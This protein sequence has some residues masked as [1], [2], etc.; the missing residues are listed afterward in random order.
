M[1]STSSSDDSYVAD[2]GN[3]VIDDF[4]FHPSLTK[5]CI[6]SFPAPK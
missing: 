1:F 5:M 6:F 4:L 3:I 2:L